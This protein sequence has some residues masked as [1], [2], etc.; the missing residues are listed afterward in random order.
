MRVLLGMQTS[1]AVLLPMLA[2]GLDAWTCDVLPCDH[3]RPDRHILEN[4][5]DVADEA[6]DLGIFMPSCTYLTNSAAWAFGDGPYHQRVKPETLVGKARRD[7]RKAAIMDVWRLMGLRYPWA[8][9]NPVG[10]ISTTIRKPDQIIHPFQFGDDASKATCLWLNG[11]PP[12]RP[13]GPHIAP[14]MV[15]GKPC[16]G[17]QTDSGQNRLSPGPDRWKKRSATWPGIGAAMAAQ[18]GST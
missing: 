3:D 15:N 1:G 2:M 18:W 12:L 9:E 6:W 7:A 4:V 13:T 5:F 10:V 8:I 17:N 16:W 11:L 14:R